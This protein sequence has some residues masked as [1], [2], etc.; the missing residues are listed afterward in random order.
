M[1]LQVHEVQIVQAATAGIASKEPQTAAVLT[2]TQAGPRPGTGGLR[3]A[4]P[5]NVIMFLVPVKH[6][7]A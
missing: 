4:H 1:G 2:S 6:K 5:T 3:A 7:I